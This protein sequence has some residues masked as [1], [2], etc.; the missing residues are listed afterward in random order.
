MK[1]S[2]LLISF[3]FL[4]LAQFAVAAENPMNEAWLSS[5]SF[6]GQIFTYK[7]YAFDTLGPVE[8]Q[9]QVRCEY[10]K[11]NELTIL[12]AIEVKILIQAKFDQPGARLEKA[13]QINIKKM[14]SD[15]KKSLST[16]A[17]A[18]NTPVQIK[19]PPISA[20]SIE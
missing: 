13:G 9:A 6:D 15:C 4:T 18:L 11:Y 7:Y 8:E 16:Q 12:K 10:T 19:L 3:I 14:I 20:S 5:S 2:K 1:L 17:L